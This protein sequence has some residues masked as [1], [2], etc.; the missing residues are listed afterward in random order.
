MIYSLRGKLIFND[1]Q[2][3]VIECGG[4]GYRFMTTPATLADITTVNGDV[5]VFTHMAVKEDGV[6]LY[7]FADQ[8]ELEMFKLLITVSGVG[9]K[10]G[11]AIL[12][13]FAPD[14]LSLLIASEDAKA[15]TSA[16]GIGTKTAQRIVLEL[17]DKVGNMAGASPI[18]SNV[19]AAK[20]ASDNAGEAIA[21]LVS[22]GY[23]RADAAV[24]VSSL[25]SSMDTVDMIKSALKI[26]ARQV[27]R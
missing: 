1:S 10:A 9:P 12:S 2:S 16:Q 26:V 5:S 27:L 22:M 6:E 23:S 18:A 24:A 15:L 17:K 25:D 19:A 14:R 20:G 21:A 8:N 3:G 4:V 7:G 13:A 11:I